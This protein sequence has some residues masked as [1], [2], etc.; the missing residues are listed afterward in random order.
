MIAQVLDRIIAFSAR[1]ESELVQARMYWDEHAGEVHD[2]N[3]LYEERASAFLEWHILE[4]PLVDGRVPAERFLAEE[5]LDD[6]EGRW[7]DALIHSHRS[8][9]Q[10]ERIK[11][12][13]AGGVIR[14]KDLFG[15]AELEITER[16]KLPGVEEGD[17]FEARLVADVISPPHVLFSRVLQFHP[18]EATAEVKQLAADD[19]RAGRPRAETLFRLARLRLKAAH[20]SHVDAALIYSGAAVP[21]PT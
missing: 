6:L 3:L 1:D 5:R 4:R 20:Y 8:I 16:R 14:V 17:V 19:A 18:R 7:V 13:A 2:D 12:E 10:V 15:G 11:P 9:L 21:E